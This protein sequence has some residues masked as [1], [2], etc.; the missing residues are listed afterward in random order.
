MTHNVL[1]KTEAKLAAL[2]KLKTRRK[3]LEEQI[4]IYQASKVK[5]DSDIELR[6][7][8]AEQLVSLRDRALS[9]IEERKP[10]VEKIQKRAEEVLKDT[11]YTPGGTD[12]E[13]YMDWI[14]EL[15]RIDAQLDVLS[16]EAN[17]I[18]YNRKSK[19]D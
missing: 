17:R 12:N 6:T 8:E 7:V 5:T 10:L 1:D 14:G 15:S 11:T 13:E 19:K 4:A 2:D 18:Y 9:L 3:N 16:D